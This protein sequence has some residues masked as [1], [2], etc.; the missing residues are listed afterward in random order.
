MDYKNYE[1]EDFLTDDRFL[2]WVNHPDEASEEFW[3][4]WIG[5]NPAK[6][7]TVNQARQLLGDLRFRGESLSA[8]RQERMEAKIMEQTGQVPAPAIAGRAIRKRPAVRYA[9]AASLAGMLLVAVIVLYRS[10]SPSG[11][12]YRTDYAEVK[13]VRL[14]DGS[15]VT[16]NANSEISYRLDPQ[17][18]DREVNLEGE[19]YFRVTHQENTTA[20]AGGATGTSGPAKTSGARRF[21]VRTAA[22]DIVVLGTE[23]NVNN[24]RGDTKV[25]LASGQVKLRFAEHIRRDRE[26]VME[27]GEMVSYSKAGSSVVLRDVDTRDYIS[28]KDNLLIFNHTPLR[29]IAR[30]LEDNYDYRV[31]IEDPQ[32]AGKVYE[33]TFPADDVTVLLRTLEKSVSLEVA[34]KQIVIREK[35]KKTNL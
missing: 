26:L 6:K 28:W 13:T 32:A 35:N 9:A 30:L 27:P 20:G 23:F 16:L 18:G 11:A 21:I 25:V 1:P 2:S 14:P 4:R 3:Q 7:E 8:E 22:M 19:A 24:R 31:R 29:E 5:E 33:G 12:V 10:F 34:G 15:E 17:T